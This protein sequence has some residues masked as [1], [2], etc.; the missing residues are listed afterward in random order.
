MKE[1]FNRYTQAVAEFLYR[2]YGRAAVA[3]A[4]YVVHCGL[5][6]SAHAAQLV[7]GD[8]LLAAELPSGRMLEQADFLIAYVW[9]AASKAANL[10][11]Y[12]RSRRCQC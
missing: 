6:H 3:A 11:E 5:S 7:D 8:V 12:A 1:V 4:D 10:L 9:H 2:R